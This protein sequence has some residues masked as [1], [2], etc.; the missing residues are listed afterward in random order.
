MT[1]IDYVSLEKATGFSL[2]H[3]R[4]IFAQKTGKPLSKYILE[5][6]ISNA[7]FEIIH[8]QETFITIAEKYGFTN[9]D[10]FTRAFKRITGLVPS[11]FRKRRMSVSRVKL[12][13]GVYGVGLPITYQK[14]DGKNE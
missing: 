1:N 9:A 3:I 14:G 4:D 10:T 7:A 11:D 13:A 5:R 2:A 6:K 12:C 8:S